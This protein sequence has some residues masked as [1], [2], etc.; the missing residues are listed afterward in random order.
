LPCNQSLEHF[1]KNYYQYNERRF[2]PGYSEERTEGAGGFGYAESTQM[3][4]CIKFGMVYD[5]D[6]QSYTG[7][8][9]FDHWKARLRPERGVGTLS[10][11]VADW[12]AAT[13][14]A[15]LRYNIVESSISRLEPA[16]VVL[17][18]KAE[19]AARGHS[20]GLSYLDSNSSWEDN[21]LKVYK[22]RYPRPF[23]GEEMNYYDSQSG[24]IIDS[25]YRM[26]CTKPP[27]D[28][29]DGPTSDLELQLRTGHL[30]AAVA[31]QY[32]MY[33][34]GVG[35]TGG[36][37]ARLKDVTNLKLMLGTSTVSFAMAF[38]RL[39]MMI[40]KLQSAWAYDDTPREARIRM[41]KAQPYDI[42]NLSSIKSDS[43]DAIYEDDRPD[44]EFDYV[45]D[46]M[47]RELG[48]ERTPEDIRRLDE[49]TGG[50]YE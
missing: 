50:D 27:D 10:E 3:P 26:D 14:P 20:I 42:Q 13:S 9:R 46:S 15:D 7:F 31:G 30:E 32:V 43:M 28:E 35:G 25:E 1:L 37:A 12:N 40:K 39:D 33:W 44:H 38:L 49:A 16:N 34:G 11:A 4:I 47:V 18:T 21:Y 19:M 8:P 29:E 17:Q 22:M 24:W 23:D 2:I 41:Q 6:S 36:A 5:T 48:S 45:D